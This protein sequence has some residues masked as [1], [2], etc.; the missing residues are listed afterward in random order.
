MGLLM[1][2]R[3][4]GGSGGGVKLVFLLCIVMGFEVVEGERLL[5]NGM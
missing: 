4:G 3:C 2:I 1:G 5:L